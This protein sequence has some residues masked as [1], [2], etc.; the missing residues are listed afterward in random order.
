MPLK[1]Y[2]VKIMA[3]VTKNI[4][5]TSTDRNTAIKQAHEKFSTFQDD[6][7]EI[8]KQDTVSVKKH[9]NNKNL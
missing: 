3:I 9:R 6:P 5:V 7:N 1:T 2:K 8:Y 4:V